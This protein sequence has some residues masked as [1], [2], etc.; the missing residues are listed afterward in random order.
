MIKHE[1]QIRVRYGEVDQMGYL[2]Y[3]NYALYYEV[4]RAEMIRSYGYPYAEMEKDGIVMPVVR[5]QARFLKPVRY[6]EHITIETTLSQL[7]TH[8]LMTFIHQLY[9]E[10]G[11]LLHR[12]EVTLTFFD[13]VQQKKV[14][15]PEKLIQILQPLFSTN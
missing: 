15:A 3:G 6:D 7:P 9:N 4:G 14:H 13:P 8:G 5:M 2:Y 1:T 11:E 10:Q 12:A